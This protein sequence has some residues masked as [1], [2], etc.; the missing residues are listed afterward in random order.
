MKARYILSTFAILVVMVVAVSGF[1]RAGSSKSDNNS[2]PGSEINNIDSTFTISANGKN[3]A[4]EVRAGEPIILSL[5]FK[6]KELNESILGQL[7]VVDL[8]GTL[9]YFD[10]DK[11]TFGDHSTAVMVK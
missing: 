5:R 4:I 1:A 2:I 6:D 11:R 7:V 9:K 10:V 3:D 8:S